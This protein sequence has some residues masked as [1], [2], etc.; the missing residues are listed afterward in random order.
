[1]ALRLPGPVLVINLGGV[2]NVTF[3]P[4]EGEIAN[5]TVAGAA[6]GTGIGHSR[7]TIYDDEGFLASS[8]TSQLIAAL[9]VARR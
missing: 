3:V 5:L 8:S 4:G 6:G 7:A 9:L 1:M 2:A